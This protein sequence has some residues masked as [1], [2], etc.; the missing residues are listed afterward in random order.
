MNVTILILSFFLCAYNLNAQVIYGPRITAM[1]NAGVAVVDIWSVQKNQA[2][3][4]GLKRP[5]LSVAYENRFGLTELS[6]KSAAFAIPIKNYA[7]GASFQSFGVDAYHEVKSGISLAKSLGPKLFAAVNLNFHQLKID[8]YGNAN[9]FSVEVGLQY[10]ALPKLWLGT[11]IAN[12]NQSK[13]GENTDQIIPAH[14]QFGASYLFSEQLMITTETEKVLDAE[15]D[16][17]TGIEYK[18]IKFIALRGGIAV[19]PFKQY[20]GFGINYQ[21]LKLDFAVGSHPLLGYSP[22]ISV[23]YEF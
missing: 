19:N 16:F 17:K 13:Y 1:G 3:I 9:S 4:A 20:A 7:I 14:I 12:P 6:T 11:H 10:E 5:E 2:G 21:K 23:G 18:I 22:Q 8:N 15:V